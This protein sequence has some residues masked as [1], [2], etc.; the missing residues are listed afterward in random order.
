MSAFDDA[1]ALLD[2]AGRFGR[3]TSFESVL[4]P[5]LAVPLDPSDVVFAC[6]VGSVISSPDPRIGSSLLGK[7]IAERLAPHVTTDNATVCVADLP[8]LV[9]HL[10]PELLDLVDDDPRDD[11]VRLRMAIHRGP[12]TTI[13]WPV[14]VGIRA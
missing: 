10:P 4:P 13:S 3:D 2:G 12:L 5:L 9:L 7:A 1:R 11:R 6:Y 8:D 14:P